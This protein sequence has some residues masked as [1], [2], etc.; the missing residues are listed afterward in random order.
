MSPDALTPWL[1]ADKLAL[2]VS[3]LLA[4]GFGAL[5]ALGVIESAARKPFLAAA[6]LSAAVA[7]LLG[8]SRLTLTSAELGDAFASANLALVWQTQSGALLAL[9]L[10]VALFCLAYLWPGRLLSAGAALAVAVSFALTGHAQGVP[11]PLLT[12]IAVAAHVAC[13][14]FWLA[15]P[16][17]IWPSARISDETLFAR[18]RGFS[19]FALAVVPMLFGLGIALALRL[20]GDVHALLTSFYGQ[21]LIAKLA[22]ASGALGLGAYN[23]LVVTHALSAEPARGR[24]MLRFA[25]V[26][27]IV[28]FAAALILVGWATTLTGPPEA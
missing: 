8:L 3:A 16:L 2:Y 26:A 15:A 7:L 11:A 4:I 13:A 28:L 19:G 21:L 24:V 20:A 17:A 25:L 5:T 1:L 27:D 14:G 23:K 22:A 18:V 9:G 6:L 12:P 10:G